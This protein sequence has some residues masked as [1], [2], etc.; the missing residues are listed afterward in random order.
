VNSIKLDTRLYS[1][2]LDA[3]G[4]SKIILDH[5][6]VGKELDMKLEIERPQNTHVYLEIGNYSCSSYGYNIIH[7]I[8]KALRSIIG[9]YFRYDRD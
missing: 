2:N 9:M 1:V 5:L 7:A 3:L 8:Y 6:N 4:L